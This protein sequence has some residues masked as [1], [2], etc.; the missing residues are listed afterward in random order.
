MR[1]PLGE[2]YF[3]KANVVRTLYQNLNDDSF[4]HTSCAHDL[5]FSGQLISF[6][7][8]NP[9][10]II[11]PRIAFVSFP[12]EWCD[13]QLAD[14]ALLTLD[15]SEKILEVGFELKDASAWN[16]LFD[17]CRPVFCDHLSFQ[18]IEKQRWWAFS[19]F[20][21]HFIFPL[22]ISKKLKL[23]AC[24]A[25]KMSRDGIQPFQVAKLLGFKRFLTRYWLLMIGNE[26]NYAKTQYSE[27]TTRSFHKNLYV[28]SRWFLQGVSSIDR[29]AS[30]WSDYAVDRNHYSDSDLNLK[31]ELIETWIKKLS[32]GVVI[33]LGCNTGEFSN[34]AATY[35]ANVIAID[36]DHNSIQSLYLSSR[37]KSISPVLANLDDLYG[38]TGWAG[39]EF[40]GLIGR[41]TAYG[42][43]LL[44]LALIHHLMISSS[45]PCDKVAQLASELTKRY[46]IVEML[47]MSDC[48]VQT[49]A[50]QRDRLP[51][52][53]DINVQ[54]TSFCK[55]FKILEEIKLP[56]SGRFILLMEKR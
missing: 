43:V 26:S 37:G 24:N 50:L 49:L 4:L 11:A 9:R 19:Q 56:D 36:S 25:F 27:K 31:K 20:A 8:V 13:A 28:L 52:D 21:R 45:I 51:D 40:S 34:I 47:N 18:K 42:D 17:H 14:A 15:I 53:F 41:L 16:I 35:G 23:Y 3:D 30:S 6:E 7:I 12:Y 32:P 22:C 10:K 33:D 39:N 46:L 38:G 55:Y 1:D 54:K 29:R 44:M 5:V 2:I 48:Q